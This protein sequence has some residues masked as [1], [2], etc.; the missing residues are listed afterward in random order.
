M[1]LK[2]QQQQKKQLWTA[3]TISIIS[4]HSWMF[5]KFCIHFFIFP[6]LKWWYYTSFVCRKVKTILTT[7]ARGCTCGGIMN[8]TAAWRCSKCCRGLSKRPK[9]VEMTLYSQSRKHHFGDNLWKENV[10]GLA[11]SSWMTH[12]PMF[13]FRLNKSWAE[14][15]MEDHRVIS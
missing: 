5:I 2:K 8:R 11:A 1:K 3:S 15:L 4:S 6:S 10:F 9:V 7:G 12:K 13:N 14:T